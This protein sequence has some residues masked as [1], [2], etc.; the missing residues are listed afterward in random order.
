MTSIA[1]VGGGPAGY[2]AAL[3]AAQL[4]AEVTLVEPEGL[5]GACV[6]YDCVPSKT[7]IATSET[8]TSFRAAP[9]LGIRTTGGPD[10]ESGEVLVDAPLVNRRVKDL[11]VWQSEDV[12]QRLSGEGVRLVTGRGRFAAEQPGAG[13]RVEV[14]DAAGQV[15]ETLDSD[16]VLIATGATPRTGRAR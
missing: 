14:V 15:T 3:V 16:V 9:A 11:A 6:L 10:G 7:L 12:R 1:I 4:G 5:G 8:M 2:E 13:R